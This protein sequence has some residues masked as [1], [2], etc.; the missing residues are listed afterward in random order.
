M[1]NIKLFIIGLIIINL[2]GCHNNRHDYSISENDR[3]LKDQLTDYY[4][5]L[6][7]GDYKKVSNYIYPALFEWAEIYYADNEEYN[8]EI[9][10]NFFVDDMVN[11]KEYAEQNS[12]DFGVEIKNVSKRISHEEQLIYVINTMLFIQKGTAR[13]ETVSIIVCVSEDKGFTWSFIEKE[14]DNNIDEML[15]LRF[16]SE[17]VNAILA[18]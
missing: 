3:R 8:K 6:F 18:I 1:K 2:T 9:F 13:Q 7:S 10:V 17:V 15:L 5:A 11:F 16:P 12:Y 14:D 4:N